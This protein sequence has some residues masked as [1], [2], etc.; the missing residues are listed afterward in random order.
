MTRGSARI[1]P[2][3]VAEQIRMEMGRIFQRDLK[4]PRVGLATCTRVQ[5]SGDL[6]VA[7]VYVSVL[8][9]PERQRDAMAALAHATGYVRRLL[10]GR[11]GLRVAPEIRFV[12]DP[13]VEYGIEL[14]RLLEE[15]RRSS[16]PEADGESDEGS[17]PDD[18]T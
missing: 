17:G 1:R 2:D 3:R 9:E 15:T 18:E 7:K 5:V 6:R 4:D 10:A 14:E 8:A 13:S 11:L 16:T 12:F